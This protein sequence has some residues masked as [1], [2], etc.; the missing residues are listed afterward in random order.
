SGLEPSA[1]VTG[2]GNVCL[3]GIFINLFL[4]FFNLF[5]FPPLDGGRVLTSV[6]PAKWA[7]QLAKIERFGILIV[8][9]LF[10]FAG[11]GT[12]LFYLI[13]FSQVGILYLVGIAEPVDVMNAF[14]KSMSAS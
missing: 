13:Q 7:M 1:V 11:L 4:A 10:M 2:F 6:L 14:F 5:P 9:A 3:A 12:L 8:L